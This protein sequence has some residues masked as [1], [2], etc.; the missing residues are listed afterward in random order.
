MG[1]G[2]ACSGYVVRVSGGVFAGGG[3]GDW[4]SMVTTPI[5]SRRRRRLLEDGCVNVADAHDNDLGKKTNLNKINSIQ[6][7][8]VCIQLRNTCERDLVVAGARNPESF[9]MFVFELVRLVLPHVV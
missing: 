3:G 7:L 6:L 8:F 4:R 2:D 5:A 9:G 1:G